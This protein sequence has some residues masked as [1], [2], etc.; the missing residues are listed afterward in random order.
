MNYYN[1]FDPYA[2]QWLRNLIDAGHIPKGEVDSRSIKDVKAS[3]L[4]GFVQCHFFAG[5]GGWSHALRLAGWPEDRPVWTGSCPCQPFS[6][7]GAGGAL[8]TSAISG[9]LGL[10]SSA[11]ADLTLS[12]VSKLTQ[13]LTTGGSTLFNLTWKQK[14][15]PAGRLVSLLRASG[16]RTSDKDCGSWLT[17]NA[18]EDAAGSLRGNMQRMLTHQAKER[19]PEGCAMGMQLNANLARWLMGIPSDWHN[20]APTATPSSRKSRKSS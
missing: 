16:R 2:A 9:L 5:L 14:V 19:D 10:T 13:R 6:A 3:D 20:C 1:E 18:N 8:P 4:T 11:S 17:P 7:A 12:L 15:T